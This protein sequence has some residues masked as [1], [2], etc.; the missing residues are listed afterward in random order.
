MEPQMCGIMYILKKPHM[1]IVVDLIYNIDA[2]QNE[3]KLAKI[4]ATHKINGHKLQDLFRGK[5]ASVVVT[6]ERKPW[7][8]G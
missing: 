8:H 1:C 5:K 7:I 3:A 2:I 6:E 4:C